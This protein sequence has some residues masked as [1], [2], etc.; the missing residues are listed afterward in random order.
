MFPI[1]DADQEIVQCPCFP[2]EWL[3]NA[4]KPLLKAVLVRR[5][6]LVL[7]S[8]RPVSLVLHLAPCKSP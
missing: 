2:T 8:N 6:T 5:L 1:I 3:W 7:S 4:N